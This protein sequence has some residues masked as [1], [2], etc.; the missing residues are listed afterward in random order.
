MSLKTAFLVL[1]IFK[2]WNISLHI[3]TYHL[4]HPLTEGGKI[5]CSLYD[6]GKQFFAYI[7]KYRNTNLKNYIACT[8]MFVVE[9]SMIYKISKKIKIPTRINGSNIMIY[10]YTQMSCSSNKRTKACNM[11]Q[12]GWKISCIKPVRRKI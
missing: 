8:S 1:R 12:N 11:L 4:P 3:S 10:V 5:S 9:F 7:C 6:T 2:L